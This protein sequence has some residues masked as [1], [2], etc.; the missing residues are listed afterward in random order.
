[1]SELHEV[2][3]LLHF[4]PAICSLSTR[5]LKRASCHSGV[6]VGLDFVLPRVRMDL[7]LSSPTTHKPRRLTSP[8]NTVSPHF[9]SYCISPRLPGRDMG[10]LAPR[11]ECR[12]ARPPTHRHQS[13]DRVMAV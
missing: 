8:S 2:D 9:L 10:L 6:E 5:R 1:M 12:D 3:D 13:A 4:T 11:R 7:L